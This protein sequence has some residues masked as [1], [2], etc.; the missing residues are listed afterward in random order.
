MQGDG[1]QAATASIL[2]AEKNRANMAEFVRQGQQQ[3][4]RAAVSLKRSAGGMIV[5]V[6]GTLGCA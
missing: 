1:A 5:T 4:Q 2:T 6:Y 3:Q